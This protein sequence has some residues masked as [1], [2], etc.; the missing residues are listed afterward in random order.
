MELLTRPFID[1][2]SMEHRVYDRRTIVFADA[3]HSE[4]AVADIVIDIDT[5]YLPALQKNIRD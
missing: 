2:C 1:T 5:I 4:G 3:D